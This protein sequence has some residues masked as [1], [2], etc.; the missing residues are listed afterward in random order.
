MNNPAI[1]IV[2]TVLPLLGYC[3]AA[4]LPKYQAIVYPEVFDGRDEGTRALKVTDDITLNLEPSSILHENF[5]LRTYR[6]G[7]AQHRYFN[8]ETLQ[9]GLYHDKR[10]Y[11]AVVLSEDGNTLQV[12]GVVGPNL[13]IRPIEMKE[14]SENGRQ[15]HL[16]ETIEDSDSDNVH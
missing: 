2:L 9:R 6:Q 4:E 7:I 8:I 11:A 14:R 13:K 15:A 1:I 12:E 16:L 5:F 10:R 3:H